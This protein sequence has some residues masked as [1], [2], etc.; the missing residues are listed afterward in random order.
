[1]KMTKLDVMYVQRYVI[2]WVGI[3]HSAHVSIIEIEL[4][5]EQQDVHRLFVIALTSGPDLNITLALINE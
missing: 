2:M 3:T 4:E 1:M 5:L